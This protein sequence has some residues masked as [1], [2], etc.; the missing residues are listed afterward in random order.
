[1]NEKTL[2]IISAV[3]TIL[4][5]GATVVSGLVGRQLTSLKISEEISKQLE[6]KG[7]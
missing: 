3:V 4:S 2:N 7:S 1:M 5:I 6:K